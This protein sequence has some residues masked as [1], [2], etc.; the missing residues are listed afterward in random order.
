MTTLTPGWFV[1]SIYLRDILEFPGLYVFFFRRY[2]YPGDCGV[3]LTKD[4]T[5]ADIHKCF[6]DK[7][8]QENTKST[9]YLHYFDVVVIG[10]EEWSEGVYVCYEG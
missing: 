3:C 5:R 1:M 10:V 9:I 8:G 4:I 7:E 6:T 2:G